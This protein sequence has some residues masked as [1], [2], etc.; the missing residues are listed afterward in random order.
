MSPVLYALL[1]RSHGLLAALALALL[2]HPVAALARGRPAGPYVRLTAWLGV[3]LLSAVFSLGLWLYPSWRGH[4]KPPLVAAADPL[5]LRFETKEHLG[6]FAIALAW[7]GAVAV[8]A[9][10][11]APALRP[12]ALTLLLSAFTCGL[13]AAAHGVWIGAHVHPAW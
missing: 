10:A 13:A 5:W 1:A 3:S 8:H 11:R 9:S 12:A 7:G 6:A 4:L 2:L